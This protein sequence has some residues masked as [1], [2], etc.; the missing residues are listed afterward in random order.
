MDLNMVINILEIVCAILLGG[1]GIYFRT[2][3]RLKETV[4]DYIAEAESAYRDTVKAGGQKHQY[5]VDHLYNLIPTYMR[6]IFTKDMVSG[7]VDRAF[8]TIEQYGKMQLDKAV[9]KVIKES[10]EKS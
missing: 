10:E 6:P 9:D 3:A 7:I 8:D 2:N 5:V 1:L 4:G